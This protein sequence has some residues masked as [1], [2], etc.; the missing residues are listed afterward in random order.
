MARTRERRRGNGYGHLG[1]RSVWH[2]AASGEEPG[3]N[4]LCSHELQAFYGL[5]IGQSVKFETKPANRR[6]LAGRPEAGRSAGG[7][8]FAFPGAGQ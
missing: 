1:I 4:R 8:R 2:N 3:R 5:H 7:F 6:L